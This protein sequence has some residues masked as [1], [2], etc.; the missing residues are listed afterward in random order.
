MYEYVYLY[1]QFVDITTAW[2]A[3]CEGGCKEYER[4]PKVDPEVCG[5]RVR[6]RVCVCSKSKIAKSTLLHFRNRRPSLSAIPK[7]TYIACTRDMQR[8]GGARERA[9]MCKHFASVIWKHQTQLFNIGSRK[10]YW[11]HVK[12]K[13]FEILPM[14]THDIIFEI[15]CFA[16]A[17]ARAHTYACVHVHLSTTVYATKETTFAHCNSF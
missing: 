1:I 5:V 12:D 14:Y 6:V 13:I 9:L 3:S 17:R 2:E 4:G 11:T 7:W 8:E 15:Q 10:I 16:N